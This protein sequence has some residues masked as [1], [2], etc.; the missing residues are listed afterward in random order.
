MFAPLEDGVARI[1][2]DRA[3]LVTLIVVVIWQAVALRNL[4][5]TVE[6]THAEVRAMRA[7][8]ESARAP[9][10]AE[11]AQR[12]EDLLSP[13]GADGARRTDADPAAARRA[14]D[15]DPSVRRADVEVPRRARKR[16]AS[17]TTGDEMLDRLYNAA[18]RMAEA[19]NWS[20]ETY[21]EVTLVFEDTA[22]AM[23]TLFRDV[24][25]GKV[26]QVAARD[27][28]A[29]LKDDATSRLTTLLGADAIDRLRQHAAP[30]R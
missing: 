24:Q 1:T 7:E 18:D 29:L 5:G 21:D 17:R 16:A 13:R 12:L 8:V 3:A 23:L 6:L 4:R 19:E 25:A 11:T 26:D 28:A 27:Q 22:D 2:F 14:G 9:S 30:G 15:A 10:S 20:D